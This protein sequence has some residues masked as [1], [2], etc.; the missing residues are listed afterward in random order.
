MKLAI[1]IFSTLSALVLIAIAG[2]QLIR[3][4]ILEITD[5][6]TEAWHSPEIH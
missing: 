2:F 3:L 5:L 4:F 6:V 1:L